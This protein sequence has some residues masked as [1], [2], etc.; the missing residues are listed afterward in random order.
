[1]TAGL[2]TDEAERFPLG[3]RNGVI[4]TADPISDTAV[5]PFGLTLRTT[6]THRNVVPV[7]VAGSGLTMATE[8]VTEISTDGNGEDEDTHFDLTP[9]I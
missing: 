7:P 2:F 6:P 8:K 9:D 5:T 4:R 1:M 3:A